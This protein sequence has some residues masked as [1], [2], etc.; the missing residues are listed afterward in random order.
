MSV[1]YFRQ[2]TTAAELKDA[3]QRVAFL[4]RDNTALYAE[5]A[6]LRLSRQKAVD[7]DCCRKELAAMADRVS[8]LESRLAASETEL[9]VKTRE[10]QAAL[11][12][13]AE[14]R[15]L[16]KSLQHEIRRLQEKSTST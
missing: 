11:D 13:A 9:D 8:Q 6:V 16:H 7:A 10:A 2:Q 14:L 5:I 4:E 1:L 12:E 3:Q 15:E